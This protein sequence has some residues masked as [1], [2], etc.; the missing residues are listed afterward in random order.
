MIIDIPKF[1]NPAPSERHI[2]C[3]GSDEL[4]SK[5]MRHHGVVLLFRFFIGQQRLIPS[6][7]FQILF[8]KKLYNPSLTPH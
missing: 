3:S 7:I 4:C 8:V 2:L 6:G 5:E 1:F